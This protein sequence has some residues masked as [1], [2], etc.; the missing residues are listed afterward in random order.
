MSLEAGG[1]VY[2][3]ST[4]P[5]RLSVFTPTPTFATTLKYGFAHKQG[6]GVMGTRFAVDGTFAVNSAQFGTQ[7]NHRLGFFTNN[8]AIEAMT[9]AT[10]NNVGIGNISPT[11]PLS[12]NSVAGNK[13]SLNNTS[14]TSQIGLSTTATDL[15]LYSSQSGNGKIKFGTRDN[16][17]Y[18]GKMEYQNGTITTSPDPT[19]ANTKVY[20][21]IQKDL[22]SFPN[23]EL[24]TRISYFTGPYTVSNMGIGSKSNN[25]FSLFVN[26]GAPLVTLNT[27]NTISLKGSSSVDGNLSINNLITDFTGTGG[28]R[29]KSNASGTK[30]QIGTGTNQDLGFITNNQTKASVVLRTN[31]DITTTK[32]IWANKYDN[33]NSLNLVP[34]GIFEASGT[35]PIGFLQGTNDIFDDTQPIFGTVT[36]TDHYRE[37]NLN[38]YLQADDWYRLYIPMNNIITDAYNKIVLTG[39]VNWDHTDE[40]VMMYRVS[41]NVEACPTPAIPTRKCAVLKFDGDNLDDFKF[42]GTFMIYGLGFKPEFYEVD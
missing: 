24:G 36:S 21:Y 33:D 14:A 19:L 20:G 6:T 10:D 41:S 34:L 5:E 25:P 38:D 1:G 32:Q 4:F 22:N 18:T 40:K 17:G 15:E 30:M 27:N 12:F 26:D 31:G 13:I 37:T 3:N 2:G 9:I 11:A 39:D 35:F 23:N 16:T 7:S 29:I 42:D 8:T 28:V